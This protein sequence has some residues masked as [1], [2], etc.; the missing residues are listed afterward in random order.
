MSNSLEKFPTRRYFEGMEDVVHPRFVWRQDTEEGI[1]ESVVTL[2]DFNLKLLNGGW[3][4]PFQLVTGAP[5]VGKGKFLKDLERDLRRRRDVVVIYLDTAEV[6]GDPQKNYGEAI[7]YWM[8]SKP[9]SDLLNELCI[10]ND[11]DVSPLSVFKNTVDI[12]GRKMP[13]KTLILL[14]DYHD[15]NLDKNQDKH[16]V[17]QSIIETCL[18]YR[19]KKQVVVCARH[20][21]VSSDITSN[22]WGVNHFRFTRYEEPDLTGVGARQGGRESNPLINSLILG[23]KSKATKFDPQQVVMEYLAHAGIPRPD[24]WIPLLEWMANISVLD[25]DALRTQLGGRSDS[26]LRVEPLLNVGLLRYEWVPQDNKG[27]GEY[28][29]VLY[30]PLASLLRG[31]I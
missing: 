5:G 30:E 24:D 29:Y 13:D 4:F 7:Y 16:R 31:E 21:E 10:F 18:A 11:P 2:N 1:V 15:D 28:K 23:Q 9:L 27:G 3:E 20:T 8:D 14:V 19:H 6:L 12:L 25:L 26:M 17:F 22:Y